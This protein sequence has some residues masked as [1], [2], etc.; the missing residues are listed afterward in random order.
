M[1]NNRDPYS[2]T[3]YSRLAIRLEH[4]L[5]QN[6]R[7]SSVLVMAADFERVAVEAT[8]ELAWHLA[9]DLGLRVILVDGSFNYSGLSKELDG[10]HKQ[11]GMLDLLTLKTLSEEAILETMQP[12]SHDRIV[13]IPT[14]L[15]DNTE[16]APAR[17]SR[18][19]EFLSIT[20]TMADFVLIQGPAVEEAK[21]TLAFGPLV[22]AVLLITL[23]GQLQV[24]KLEG[25]QKILSES[26]A[27]KVGLV[28]GTS[29]NTNQQD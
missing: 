13:F 2:I 27:E 5:S 3:G 25:A 23:E 10:E 21:R 17:S 20:N 6:D 8:T 24:S 4:D 15:G 22:D 19:K 9:D 14:G 12:T 7:G 28:I 1:S 11:P 18:L 29:R 16:S 26:G